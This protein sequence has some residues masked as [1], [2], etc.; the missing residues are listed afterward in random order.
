MVAFPCNDL[1]LPYSLGPCPM[2]LEILKQRNSKKYFILTL[3]GFV[4][5][6]LHE[7]DAGKI[8]HTAFSYRGA[9][10]QIE[11][12]IILGQKKFLVFPIIPRLSSPELGLAW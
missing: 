7:N 2:V 9:F 5:Q 6:E 3:N 10:L 1:R 4:F 11:N 12:Q 8:K